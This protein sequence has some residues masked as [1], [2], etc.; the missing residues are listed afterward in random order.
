MSDTLFKKSICRS[1]EAKRI[2]KMVKR[3]FG[4]HMATLYKLREVLEAKLQNRK[5]KRG[6]RRAQVTILILALRIVLICCCQ[7]YPS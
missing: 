3:F 1:K 6:R 2:G 5:E 4:G 7:S